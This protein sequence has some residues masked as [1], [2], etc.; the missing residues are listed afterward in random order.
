M[1]LNEI[2]SLYT[3]I[4]LLHSL[5]H[6]SFLS[7]TGKTKKEDQDALVEWFVENQGRIF[8]VIEEAHKYLACPCAGGESARFVFGNAGTS[9]YFASMPNAIK[10]WVKTNPR[11][12]AFT[13]T[14]SVAQNKTYGICRVT[15]KLISKDRLKLVPHATLSIE[16]K[17]LQ[18]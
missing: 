9:P 3:G 4:S 10:D 12:I 2:I 1:F 18:K 5:T 15:G 17:N 6:G 11:V 16:A 7:A 14:P 13:A 8:L